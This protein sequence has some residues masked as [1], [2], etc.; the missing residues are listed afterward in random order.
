MSA[1]LRDAVAAVIH[2]ATLDEIRKPELVADRI[3]AVLA[4][5][6]AAPVDAEPVAWRCFDKIMEQWSVIAD[7]AHAEARMRQPDAWLVH[8]LY[9]LPPAEAGRVAEALRKLIDAICADNEH[10][11]GADDAGCLICRAVADGEAAL[12][13]SP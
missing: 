9:A 4:H 8:P 10:G 6:P 2:N 5:L 7:R 13:I 12:R 11:F 3:L 1:E